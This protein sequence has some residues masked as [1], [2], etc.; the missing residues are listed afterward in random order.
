MKNIIALLLVVITIPAFA[1]DS[2]STKVIDRFTMDFPHA[3]NVKWY[4]QDGKMSVSYNAGDIA[5]L[6][7]YNAAGEVSRT[8][9]YYEE[10][11]L[12]TFIKNKIN[13][14]FTDKTIYGVTEISDLKGHNYYVTLQDATSWTQIKCDASGDITIVK[15]MDKQ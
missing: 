5:Y 10:K 8:R 1:T 15:E 7:K 11:N 9:M 6:V 13:K 4:E 3:E 12:T 14:E 2:L